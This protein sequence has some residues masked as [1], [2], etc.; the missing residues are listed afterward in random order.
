MEFD[1]ANKHYV[2]PADEALMLGYPGT[3]QHVPQS[4]AAELITRITNKTGSYREYQAAIAMDGWRSEKAYRH[5]DINLR[6]LER[7]G[8]VV[9]THAPSAADGAGDYL[10]LFR[11]D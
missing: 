3:T 11:L 5:A 4:E 8:D 9:L 1:Q 2:L 10:N 7:M 6:L